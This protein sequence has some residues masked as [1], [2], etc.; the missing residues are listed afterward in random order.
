MSALAEVFRLDAWANAITGLGTLRDKVKSTKVS[1]GR[2][3]GDAEIDRLIADDDIA[4]RI[5]DK[6]PREALRAGWKLKFDQ[7]ETKDATEQWKALKKSLIKLGVDAK[8]L[9]AWIWGRAFGGGAI[10]IGADDG[11]DVSEPL[12]E[13]NIRTLRYLHVLERRELR[14]HT[15]Y[16]DVDQPKY[17]EPE[18]YALYE[19]SRNPFGGTARPLGEYVHE[20]RLVVFGGALTTKWRRLTNIDGWDDSVLQRCFEAM[21]QSVTAWQST[22]NLMSDASQG[23]LKIKG[24]SK[25]IT[26]DPTA[27][28]TRMEWMDL[29]RSVARSIMVDAEF[30]GF[31]RVATSFASIP[32]LLDRWMMRVAAAAEMPVTMLFGRS[33]AGM[34]ATGD[35]DTRNWY[36]VVEE[37]QTSVLQPRL[38]RLVTLVML[39]KDGPTNGE[40]LEDW[41]IEFNSL[42]EPSEAE[43]AA[44][45]KSDADTD[46]AYVT[47]QVLLPEQVALR[48]A[49]EGRYP[50]DVNALQEIVEEEVAG[51]VERAGEPPPAPVIAAPGVKTKALPAPDD[52]GE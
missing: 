38:E 19:L 49:K 1:M 32:E 36:Q 43:A 20:T 8:V 37:A 24:L 25:L 18:L 11:R 30:E 6:V 27:L 48:L 9:E 26:G 13:E 16:R 5:V 42:R 28:R 3:L 29:A 52:G 40:L 2:K 39:A 15:R 47:A 33:P 22:A 14:V 51:M 46:C 17:G 21:Q 10:L 12:D 50:L 34:N 7:L 23:V 35:S 44:T 4:T 45:R 41:E 31:E